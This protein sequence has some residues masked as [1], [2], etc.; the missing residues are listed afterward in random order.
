LG[1]HLDE[2][3][4]FDR[5]FRLI[6]GRRNVYTWMWRF[7]F[8]AGLPTHVF[9]AALAWAIVTVGVHGVRLVYHLRRRVA[10]A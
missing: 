3:G 8:W 9:V 2:L 6:A 7:G 4:L 10:V 5:N 1:K